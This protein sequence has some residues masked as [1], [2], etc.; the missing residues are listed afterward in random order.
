MDNT[1]KMDNARNYPKQQ[2]GETEEQYARR[3]NEEMTKRDAQIDDDFT[4][5][6]PCCESHS[7]KHKKG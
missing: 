4:G 6:C 7:P 5:E 1:R 2:P 3:W